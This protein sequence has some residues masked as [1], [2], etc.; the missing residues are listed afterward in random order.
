MSY[1]RAK[2]N[3]P[4]LEK[5]DK[6]FQYMEENKISIEKMPYGGY[7]ITDLE[8]NEQWILCNSEDEVNRDGFSDVG[9]PPTLEYK[10]VR[11]R[12]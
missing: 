5:L 3:H 1:I 6:L 7:E 4:F 9:L 11:E 8:A 2:D 12:S 10:I